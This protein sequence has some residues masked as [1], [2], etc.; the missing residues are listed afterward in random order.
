[1]IRR[2]LI[3]IATALPVF[4]FAA[5][6]DKPI[7]LIQGFAAGGNADV[8]ARIV[9][10]GMAKELGQPVV[11]EAKLGAGGNVASGLVAKAAADGYTLILL[12]GG[13]PCLARSI[14]SCRLIRSRTLTGCRW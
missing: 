2:A 6:P 9:A 4:S 1:M 7:T 14:K 10:A 5:F 13:H 11:V 12:T 8:I 3:S